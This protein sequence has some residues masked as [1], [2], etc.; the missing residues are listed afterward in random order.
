MTNI[1]IELS[2]DFAGKTFAEVEAG[3]MAE[4]RRRVGPA[5]QT[6]LNA[7]TGSMERRQVTGLFGTVVIAR[8]RLE[9]VPC[10]TTGYPVDQRLGLDA[11]A[12]YSL[13]IAEA[14]LSP[15][16]APAPSRHASCG[17]SA[18]GVPHCDTAPRALPHR[19]PLS[20]RLAPR[21]TPC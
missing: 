18:M 13:G 2:V 5:L 6:E 3:V 19:H 16:P 1:V 10:A 9:C 12:R 14:A 15:P 20:R 21:E 7:L 4:L 11:G 17:S 8:P